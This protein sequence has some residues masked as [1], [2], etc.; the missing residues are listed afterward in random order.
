MLDRK[1]RENIPS[2]NSSF[3]EEIKNIEKKY[4]TKENNT[5]DLISIGTIG[6]IKGIDSFKHIVM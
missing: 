2:S 1:Y 5:D 4:D 6:L 3:E